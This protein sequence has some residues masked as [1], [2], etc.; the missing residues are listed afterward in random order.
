M[1]GAR[2]FSHTSGPSGVT[3]FFPK[4]V[5]KF[6]FRGFYS[7]TTKLWNFHN[8]IYVNLRPGGRGAKHF[9]C[10]VRMVVRMGHTFL[11]HIFLKCYYTVQRV[12]RHFFQLKMYGRGRHLRFYASSREDPGPKDVKSATSLCRLD[13]NSNCF[14]DILHRHRAGYGWL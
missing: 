7:W 5:S 1:W 4:T 13:S 12:L 3:V 11:Q 14:D 2:F 6:I 9:S 8:I 10:L